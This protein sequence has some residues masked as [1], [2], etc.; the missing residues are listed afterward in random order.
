MMTVNEVSRLTG[1]SIRALHY[2]DQIG[3]LPATGHTDS[4]YRLYDDTA[5]AALQQILLFR[6]MEFPL[7]DIRQIMTQPGID[8][9]KALVQQMELLML[10]K[11]RLENLIDLARRMQQTGGKPMDFT[12]FDTTKLEEYAHQAKQAWGTTPAYQ[13]FEEKSTKRTPQESNTI[14]AQLMAIVAAF[15]TL[16]TRP[17]QDPAVQAQVKTLKDFITRHYYTCNKQILAQLGQMY[18][19]GGEFTKNINAAGGPGAAEFAAR[20]IEYYCRGEET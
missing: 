9:Q 3:L 18:A 7:K 19:A 15:G 20:A 8:R 5:L 4:G 17:A 10:K 14:N 11:Q 2:Y 6:E 12:A 13:E 1:V 16:Q